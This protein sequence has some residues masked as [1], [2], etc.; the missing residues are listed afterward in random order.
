MRINSPLLAICVSLLFFAGCTRSDVANL[1]SKGAN[2]ICFGDSL[3]SG[4]GAGTPD[5][6]YPAVLSR[7]TSFRVI[8]AG[9]NGD[10]SQEALKRIRSDVLERD[11]LIVI[12]EFG[13]N[14]FLG[15]TPA[16]ETVRN[17]ERMIGELRENGVI[18]ALCDIS[19]DFFMEEYGKEFRRLSR[20]Y[21]AILI[22]GL[23]NDIIANPDLKSDYIHPNAKGYAIIAHRV[24]RAIIPYLNQNS[25]LRRARAK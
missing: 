4:M 18:V 13:G 2:I 6:A 8:N 14:D 9:I 11:P 10:T 21:G 22:P 24:Y 7:M 3:T 20:E 12:I 23:L 16:G 15:H 17:I 19:T 1:S 25:I 5:R